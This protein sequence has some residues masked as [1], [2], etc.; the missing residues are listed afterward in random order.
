MAKTTSNVP[1]GPTHR[2]WDFLVLW[3]FIYFVVFII[4]AALFGLLISVAV[5]EMG[6][7]PAILF[8]VIPLM[9]LIHFATIVGMIVTYI[10]AI[11]RLYTQTDLDD[12]QK[13]I[14]LI[15]I[16]LFNII[17]IPILHFQHLRR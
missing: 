14:W 15:L 17:T 13:R 1:A 3:P 5:A 8:A 2:F 11:H 7:P 4:G 10:Y 9:F 16:I 12:D 6:E